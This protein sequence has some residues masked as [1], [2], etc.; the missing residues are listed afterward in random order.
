MG[1]LTIHLPTQ[2][3]PFNFATMTEAGEWATDFGRLEENIKKIDYLEMNEH[4]TDN[5]V[6]VLL[7]DAYELRQTWGDTRY[8][9][10]IMKWVRLKE[11][12]LKVPLSKPLDNGY[13]VRMGVES[14]KKKL[15]AAAQRAEHEDPPR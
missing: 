13:A 6:K 3:V 9:V 2:R 8:P 10:A 7:D 15:W 11:R 12:L 1:W 5:F 4:E 14:W